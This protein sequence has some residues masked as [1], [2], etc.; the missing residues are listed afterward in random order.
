MPT[1]QAALNTAGPAYQL[2]PT[3]AVTNEFASPAVIRS[4]V[5]GTAEHIDACALDVWSIGTLLV[6]LF[7]CLSAWRLPGAGT[8]QLPQLKAIH[9]N[10]VRWHTFL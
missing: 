4:Q 1:N 10:W 2:P 7:A 5:D 6:Q 9:D 8:P 3:F